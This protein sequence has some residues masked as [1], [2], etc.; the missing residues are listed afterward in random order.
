MRLSLLFLSYIF[1]MISPEPACQP[2]PGED[3]GAIENVM[4]TEFTRGTQ[5]S[6]EVTRVETTVRVNDQEETTPTSAETWQ[7]L[8]QQVEELPLATLAKI[9]VL[10]K[11][12]QSDAAL[13]ATLRVMAGD[14]AYTSDTFDHNAPPEQLRTIVDS[15]YRQIPAT[16]KERFQR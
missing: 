3:A 4:L 8:T 10:S 11:K 13:H 5:R 16:L 9:P 12:H 2:K 1:V 7:S 15:L 6:I 14:S